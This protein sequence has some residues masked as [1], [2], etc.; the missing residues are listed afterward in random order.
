MKR[1][2]YSIKKTAAALAALTLALSLCACS[3]NENAE[4][5]KSSKAAQTLPEE[6]YQV[7]AE[8]KDIGYSESDAVTIA[9]DG[10]TAEIS[11]SGADCADGVL[12]ITAEGTYIL[13]GSFDGRI[14]VDSQKSDI[15]LVLDGAD[16]KSSGGPALYVRK[17]SKVTLTLEEGSKNSFSDSSDYSQAE[18]NADAAVFSKAD[19][20]INGSG[21]LFI[22]GNYKHGAVSK[23]NLAITGGEISVESVS[24]AVSGKDSVKISDGIIDINAGTNGITSTNSEEA[25][26]G[27]VALSGGSI[28]ITAGGDGID[29]ENSLLVEGGDI[30]INTGGG[31]ENAS[32]KSDGSVNENWGKWDRGGMPSGDNPPPEMP[33]GDPFTPAAY[34]STSEETDSSES[35]AKGLK[36]GGS[37]IISGGTVTI[38]S[39]DDSVH[40]NG[41]VDISSGTLTAS[42]GDD[43][44]HA[45]SDLSISGGTVDIKKSY[46]GIE[47]LNINVSGGEISVVSSDDGF[48]AAGGSDTG[49]ENRPGMNGF[50]QTEDGVTILLEI[51]GGTVFVNAEGDGL[52]S[53]GDLL[54]SGGDIIVEGP[55][56]S[57]NGALD[58]GDMGCTAQI[59]GGRII[60]LGSSGMAV[61]F[62]DGS[63]QY[64][65]LHNFSSTASAGSEFTVTDES[66]NVIMS[67]TPTKSYQSAVFSC[68]E[69]SDGA[70]TVSAGELSE[71]ITLSSV[72]TSN[73]GGGFGG[74]GMHGGGRGGFGF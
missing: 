33:Q 54:I 73:G 40:S 12:N 16:V 61:G 6:A 67:Y 65:V 59:T 62:G 64:N 13:S 25:D 45:D 57:G 4:S 28:S 20:T 14:I 74:G 51:S 30:V 66:G 23:D 70:Y 44:I 72:C 19:L 41:I 5:T 58:Y 56:S 10:T 69:L 7:A 47:G 15:R 63:T 22:S 35:S 27:V 38:D 55:Q 17:A 52:D 1:K 39:S 43:G 46:E 36:A 71:Q 29:A 42:S 37:V 50:A 48:N 60:A 53:N 2:K 3:D 31:S 34:V 11:G 18:E 9:F 8:D 24:T 26:K 68:P 49:M 32:T 21:S